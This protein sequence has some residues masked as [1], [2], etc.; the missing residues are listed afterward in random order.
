M[1]SQTDPVNDN[2]EVGDDNE[3]GDEEAVDYEDSLESDKRAMEEID[4]K[5]E[6]KASKLSQ[7][8]NIHRKGGDWMEIDM[9]D[10]IANKGGV[11]DGVIEM[12]GE[13]NEVEAD[14]FR[15]VPIKKGK[16]TFAAR[17]SKRVREKY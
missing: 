15:L 17:S 3:Y 11:G 1:L 8:L 13:E 12:S 10:M 9:K 14:Q 4:A 6:E 7:F 2:R 5:F 16:V